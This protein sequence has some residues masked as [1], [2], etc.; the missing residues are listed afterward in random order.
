MLGSFE[1]DPPLAK[2]HYGN[3]RPTYPLQGYYSLKENQNVLSPVFKV[4]CKSTFTGVAIPPA[5]LRP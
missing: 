5:F 4:S 3:W 2:V 1:G